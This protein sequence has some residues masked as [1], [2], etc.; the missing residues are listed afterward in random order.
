MNL[1]LGRKDCSLRK[2]CGQV[3]CQMELSCRVHKNLFE[4]TAIHAVLVSITITA[5]FIA[6]MSLERV[7]SVDPTDIYDYIICG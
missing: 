6:T 7:D 1:L 5:S 2:E 3:P 4:A